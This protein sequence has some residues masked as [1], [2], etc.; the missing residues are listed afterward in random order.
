[1]SET[2]T[3]IRPRVPR[4]CDHCHGLI[5]A[6]E[7]C[8]KRKHFGD[9]ISTYYVHRAC[10]LLVIDLLK[11]GVGQWYLVDRDCDEIAAYP[12]ALAEH[13]AEIAADLD[14]PELAARVRAVL[15]IEGK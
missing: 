11:T 9:Y 2:T 1:M 3:I 12:G 10:D 13:G 14:D 5:P 8:I 4:Y 15:R 6:G 7:Q